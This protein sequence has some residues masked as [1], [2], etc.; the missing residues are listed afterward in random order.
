[1]PGGRQP[2]CGMQAQLVRRRCPPCDGRSRFARLSTL[3]TGFTGPGSRTANRSLTI[4]DTRAPPPLDAAK[5]QGGRMKTSGATRLRTVLEHGRALAC[6]GE[7]RDTAASQPG[8]GPGRILPRRT[9]GWTTG[10]PARN[11]TTSM[12]RRASASARLRCARCTLVGLDRSNWRGC[13]GGSDNRAS[14]CCGSGHACEPRRSHSGVA[15]LD[16]QC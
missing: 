6:S 13:G 8:L 2:P 12:P 3:C 7:R 5:A 4:V 15:I 11:A 14:C 16:L 9:T 10:G 1:M